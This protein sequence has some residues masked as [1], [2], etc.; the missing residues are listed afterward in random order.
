MLRSTLVRASLIGFVALTCAVSVGIPARAGAAEQSKADE[1]A[2]LFRE[3]AERSKK[4]DWAGAYDL[5]EKSFALVPAAETATNLGQAAYKM[6]KY[7]EAARYLAHAVRTMSP[8]VPQSTRDVVAGMYDEAKK[9]VATLRLTVTPPGAE[10]FV[11]GTSRGKAE[12]LLD[13]VFVSP[14]EHVIEARAD[15]YRPAREAITAARGTERDL[16]LTLVREQ[17]QS[18]APGLPDSGVGGTTGEGPGGHDPTQNGSSDR[19]ILP[20]VLVGGGIT[21]IAAGIGVGFLIASNGTK[22]DGD[23]LAEE[24]DALGGC[25]TG[26]PNADRCATLRDR[27]ET[28]DTQRNISTVGFIGA[29]VAAVGTLVYILLSDPGQSSAA[30]PR[31]A[32][33]VGSLSRDGFAI[34][35]RGAF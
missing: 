23:A 12:N 34:G 9:E 15:G 8:T 26:T 28:A 21:L 27:Y 6:S 10:V 24:L 25:A 31:A 18:A 20:A 14:G 3:A 32:E 33:P 1:A 19:T 29:G 5:L 35:L 7:A 30:K 4:K 11:D 22:S 2:K 17:S 13:P 16:A